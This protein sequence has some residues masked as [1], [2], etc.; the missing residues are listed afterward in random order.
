MLSKQDRTS[1]I[2]IDYS[3]MSTGQLSSLSRQ[4]TVDITTDCFETIR[5]PTPSKI[6]KLYSNV[7][8][9]VSNLFVLYMARHVNELRDSSGYLAI[10]RKRINYSSIPRRYKP[11][12]ISFDYL[13]DKTVDQLIKRGLVHQ[14]TGYK[15][16]DKK[17]R[18]VKTRIK[19]T[20]WL[21]D[22]FK[23]IYKSSQLSGRGRALVIRNPEADVI[24]LK[25]NN[26]KLIDYRE[27][28]E[29]EAMRQRLVAFNSYLQDSPRISL[30]GKPIVA[31]LS[32]YRVFSNGSFEQ[33]GRFYGG[34]WQSIPSELRCGITIDAESTVEL[35]YS[36]LNLTVLY[37]KELQQ[38]V[39][40]GDLYCLAEY[41]IGEKGNPV[42][43]KASKLAALIMLNAG[44]RVKAH[45]ALTEK[46][47]TMRS[48][49]DDVPWNAKD[50]INA[51]VDKHPQL[52]PYFFTGHG[53]EMQRMDS[54]IADRILAI[55]VDRDI[56]VLPIHDS[57]IV[58]RSDEDTLLGIMM[59]EYLA[60]TGFKPIVH[61]A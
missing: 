57:Y 40:E 2:P 8:V 5:S 30:N 39:P 12:A 10:D 42:A 49:G 47:C 43:R 34:I 18:G 14:I 48:K 26:K 31:G 35:D 22:R 7:D 59:S 21:M 52:E 13:I 33:G 36:T 1:Y 11:I 32:L 23:D 38:D 58:K 44:S 41:G 24:R 25:D 16:K 61:V 51:F 55:C 54:A 37:H 50:I 53:L 19:A 4:I 29:T 6:A 15:P 46:L 9:L 56:P 28:V 60:V 45:Y 27:T 17:S 3:L 20:G